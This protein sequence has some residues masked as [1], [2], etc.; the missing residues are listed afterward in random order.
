M[1]AAALAII[2]VLASLSLLL[3]EVQAPWSLLGAAAALGLG[4]HSARRALRSPCSSLVLRSD[5]SIEVDGKA[6]LDFHASFQGPLTQLRWS[7][8]RRTQRLVAW[9]DVLDAPARRELRLWALVHRP[10]GRAPAV[11][12]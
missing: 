5:G 11:A 1:L 8:Q 7:Q 3:S 10:T 2:G 12:G 6:A 4:T 9:P